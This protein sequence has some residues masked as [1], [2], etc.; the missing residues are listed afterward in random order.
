MD[1]ALRDTIELNLVGLTSIPLWAFIQPRVAQ[2][3]A[4]ATRV[5]IPL[6]YR[7]RNHM[8][9]MYFGVLCAGADASLGLAVV[10][11]MRQREAFVVPSFKSMNAEFL[12][13]PDGDVEFRNDSVAETAAAFERALSTGERVNLE[14]KCTALLAKTREPVAIFTAMLS[15]KHKPGKLP[16]AQR[17]LSRIL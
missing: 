9:S 1:L 4:T 7:T 15:M 16:L 5:R 12:R 8:G 17:I 6:G 2:N 10:R 14:V 13:R 3:D 11:L